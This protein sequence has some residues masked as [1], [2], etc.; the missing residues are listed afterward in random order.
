MMLLP[1]QGSYSHAISVFNQLVR[2][3]EEK[4]LTPLPHPLR[5]YLV[6]C[7]LEHVHDVD[8]VDE[9]IALN[10]LRSFELRGEHAAHFLKR[11]GDAALLFA[12]FFP[13]RARH[14]RVGPDY[15]RFMGKG[16][17]YTLATDHAVLRESARR[18]FYGTV[19]THYESLER[20]LQGAR[21]PTD[22]P[23]WDSF[24][25]ALMLTR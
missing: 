13:E 18:K 14:M 1:E 17:Y 2:A 11:A 20:V 16:A 9:A 5:E 24:L 19:V 21:S 22:D 10:Y 6:W 15:F 4:S 12:G 23:G 25:H 3:G 7:L 8:I